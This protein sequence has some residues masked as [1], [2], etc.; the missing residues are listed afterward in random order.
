MQV[1]RLK[2]TAETRQS[3]VTSGLSKEVSSTERLA[4]TS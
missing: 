2:V 4:K 3:C 1:C